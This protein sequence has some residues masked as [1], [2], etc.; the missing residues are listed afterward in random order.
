MTPKEKAEELV[1]KIGIQL[2]STGILTKEDYLSKSK[3]CALICVE[4]LMGYSQLFDDPIEGTVKYWILVK[5]EI[6]KL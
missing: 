4:E 2:A 6:E 5:E 1:D 3:R